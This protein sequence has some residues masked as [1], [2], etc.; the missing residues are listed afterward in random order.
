[1][2]NFFTKWCYFFLDLWFLAKSFLL[3]IKRA[4]YNRG[5]KL[6]W[7]RLWIR[8]DE[9]H[10]S[11]NMDPDAILGVNKEQRDAYM[12]DLYRRRQIAHRRNFS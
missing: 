10:S 1:M 5:I 6:Q 2:K 7:N 9:F 8:G 12:K 4:I 11:L 3:K